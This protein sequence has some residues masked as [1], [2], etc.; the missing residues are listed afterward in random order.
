MRRSKRQINDSDD[1]NHDED[2]EESYDDS[3]E[4]EEEGD[5]DIDEQM[6]LG[7]DSDFEEYRDE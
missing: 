1:E 5:E 6:L 4:T 7:E 3:E 2:D